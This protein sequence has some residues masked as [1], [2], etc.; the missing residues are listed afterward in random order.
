[1][2]SIM[3]V[4]SIL[5]VSSVFVFFIIGFCV[6][7]LSDESPTLGYAPDDDDGMKNMAD[8]SLTTNMMSSAL[9]WLSD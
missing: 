2:E 5:L 1:M 9:D 6:S 3:D 4:M 7:P 8:A